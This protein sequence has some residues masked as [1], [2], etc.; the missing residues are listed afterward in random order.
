MRSRE[1]PSLGRGGSTRS[2]GEASIRY[3]ESLEDVH[4]TFIQSPLQLSK[5]RKNQPASLAHASL[6][7]SSSFERPLSPRAEEIGSAYSSQHRQTERFAYGS[8]LP[9]NDPLNAST[10]STSSAGTRFG[11]SSTN[12]FNRPHPDRVFK[13]FSAYNQ[14]QTAMKTDL[15]TGAG[16]IHD[17]NKS[18][19]RYEKD[20][21]AKVT[22]AVRERLGRDNQRPNVDVR[23]SCVFCLQMHFITPPCW[24]YSESLVVISEFALYIISNFRTFVLVPILLP[25]LLF[26]SFP[27]GLPSSPIPSVFPPPL[28]LPTYLPYLT[29]SNS[30]VRGLQRWATCV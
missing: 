27:F 8:Q 16:H 18:V 13:P 14:Q 7:T 30:S 1:S 3:Q 5:I 26:P 10:V 4:P 19:R 20:I 22:D 9:A 29:H 12:S 6:G 21:R 17:F 15:I 2:L 23:S 24:Y 11:N 25:F 28:S